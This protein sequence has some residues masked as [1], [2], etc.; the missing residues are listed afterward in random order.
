MRETRELFLQIQKRRLRLYKSLD[1]AAA[2][3]VRW[4]HL[5]LL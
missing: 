1:V 5:Q 3:S 4:T 2:A